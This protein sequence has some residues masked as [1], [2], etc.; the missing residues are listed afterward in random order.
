[1]RKEDWDV[2]FSFKID[3][4][5]QETE[6]Y[7]NCIVTENGSDRYGTEQAIS[8]L[9]EE[10]PPLVS[11]LLNVNWEKPIVRVANNAKAKV[12]SKRTYPIEVKAISD[13]SITRENFSILLNNTEV[14]GALE[15]EYTND[16]GS[17]EGEGKDVEYTQYYSNIVEL[18]P[19]MN[20]I[21]VV[22]TNAAGTKK[23][24]PHLVRYSPPKP[25]LYVLAIA[26]KSWE[27]EY[28]RKDARAFA[29][30]MDKQEQR[31]FGKVKT[32]VYADDKISGNYNAGGRQ[33]KQALES[34]VSY[35]NIQANTTY[36][37]TNALSSI[38]DH[39]C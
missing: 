11:N 30:I 37:S 12:V 4:Y 38:V 24:I 25:N 16:P 33:I 3:Q 22:V 6:V 26:P 32:T 39:G 31:I 29:A 36:P 21:E 14:K 15:D 20:K 2:N 23:T 7:V 9:L 28:N 8:I 13:G 17:V 10:A 1:V 18:L 34:L 27:L 5:Y 35:N 19:G